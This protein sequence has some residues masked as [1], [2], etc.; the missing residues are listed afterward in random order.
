M[1][2]F[3]EFEAALCSMKRRGSTTEELIVYYYQD[4]MK[5]QELMQCDEQCHL[6][7]SVSRSL[8]FFV[9]NNKYYN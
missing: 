6:V 4:R 1:Y 8:C 3:V 5:D 7:L 2:F 9:S